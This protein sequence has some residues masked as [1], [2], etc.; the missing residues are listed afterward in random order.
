MARFAPHAT[1]VRVTKAKKNDVE[2]WKE[3][4]HL[5]TSGRTVEELVDRAVA[6]RYEF[7]IQFFRTAER[8]FSDRRPMYRLA[9]SRYYYSMYHA[10]RA[11]AY[12]HHGGDDHEEHRTL[13]GKIPDDM[14]NYALLGNTLKNARERR[15]AAD[16]EPYPKSNLAWEVDAADLRDSARMVLNE[17]R[18][19][20]RAKGCRFI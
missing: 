11:A 19:Y 20:L 3:G 1:L 9:V 18:T 6:D 15:N 10:L 12:K 13:P 8:A 14:P 4:R 17:V 16:Y 2:R 5:E 7:A